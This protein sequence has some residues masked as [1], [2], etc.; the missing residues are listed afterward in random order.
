MLQRF[1]K[2]L[3]GGTVTTSRPFQ[4]TVQS[5]GCGNNSLK[6]QPFF[7]WGVR[8]WVG[9]A[10][11]KH[12][13]I[14]RKLSRLLVLQDLLTGGL[15][16]SALK[17]IYKSFQIWLPPSLLVKNIFGIWA[18]WLL[19][20]KYIWSLAFILW[21]KGK[22]KSIFFEHML[23]EGQEI[24]ALFSPYGCQWEWKPGGWRYWQNAVAEGAP[25]AIMSKP[26]PRCGRERPVSLLTSN[27][28]WPHHPNWWF[29]ILSICQFASGCLLSSLLSRF[30]LGMNITLPVVSRTLTSLSLSRSSYYVSDCLFFWNLY[31]QSLNC[32]LQRA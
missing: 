10:N 8:S 30:P 24:G 5:F 28:P 19:T 2:K 17:G 32:G 26:R 21:L 4:R 25:W 6:S 9:D 15:Q 3:S 18:F 11:Q 22:R 13:G 7:P 1:E 16:N 14:A 12:V 23:V 29:S 27:I 20:E 31:L